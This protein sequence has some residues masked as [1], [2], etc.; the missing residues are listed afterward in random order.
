MAENTLLEKVLSLQD[1]YQSLQDQLAS[2]DIC[3]VTNMVRNSSCDLSFPR[4]RR[5]LG[6][7]AVF[8]AGAA[9]ADVV[10]S[11]KSAAEARKAQPDI[12]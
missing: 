4:S 11:A 9:V 5:A 7:R 3:S 8:V 2:P 10:E 1:K 6:G 12:L